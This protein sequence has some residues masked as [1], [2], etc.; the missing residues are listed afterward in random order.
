MAFELK[1]G[2]LQLFTEKRAAGNQPNLRGKIVIGGATIAIAAWMKRDKNNN[3]YIFGRVDDRET[4]KLAEASQPN[5][6][7]DVDNA[8]PKSDDDLRF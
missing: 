3:P 5:D 1:E 7:S 6:G 4:A 2:Q 8:F